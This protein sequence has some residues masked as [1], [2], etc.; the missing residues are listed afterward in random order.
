MLANLQPLDTQLRRLHEIPTTFFQHLE[1]AVA[2]DNILFPDWTDTAF[3]GTQLKAKFKTIYDKYKALADPNERVKIINAFTNN[4]QVAGLCS[5]Q[6]GTLCIPLSELHESIREEIDK[7]F[8]YLYKT[9]LEY[10]GFTNHVGDNVR[11]ATDRFI[12]ACGM[13]ICPICGLEGY[14]NLT[15]QSRIA[16]DHWLCKDLFPVISVNFDNLFPLGDKC[17]GRPAK[18][19]KN[20]LLDDHG[21]RVIAFYAFQNHHSITASFSYFNEP[22]INPLTDADWNLNIA[23]VDPAEQVLFD[24]WN[25]I[26]N[27]LERYKDYFKKYIFPLWENDYKSFVEESGI[28]HADNVA[29]LKNKLTIWRA[30]FKPKSSVGAILHR[31]FIDNMINNCSEAYLYSLCE[32]FK[33]QSSA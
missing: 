17:N 24:S 4:N 33:S 30:S 29:E 6:A 16:L 12:Q 11:D 23:P 14:M 5:N 20:I 10:E 26:F 1:T 2:F 9:A 22:S 18:G 31:A 28:G 32:N 19:S 21:N 7:V 13:Q 8:L 15:G 25:S 3:A 27:I